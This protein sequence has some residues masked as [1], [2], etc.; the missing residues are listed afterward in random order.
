[1]TII[2]LLFCHTKHLALHDNIRVSKKK[3]L[4]NII[5]GYVLNYFIQ[6]VFCLCFAILYQRN[7]IRRQ[8]TKLEAA[9]VGAFMQ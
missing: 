9:I 4:N 6:N 2:K 7:N 5:N 8:T 3:C 1:M